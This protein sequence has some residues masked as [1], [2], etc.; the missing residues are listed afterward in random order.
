MICWREPQAPDQT[1]TKETRKHASKHATRTRHRRAW[2]SS[3]SHTLRAGYAEPLR[4]S[5]LPFELRHTLSDYDHK[6]G[7][8]V[9]DQHKTG[10]NCKTGGEKRK[11]EHLYKV[12]HVSRERILPQVCGKCVST[13]LAQQETAFFL[14]F[15]LS[16]LKI[17]HLRFAVEHLSP[18]LAK[19]SQLDLY[20]LEFMSHWKGDH[21]PQSQV[22][23]L[24]G[25]HL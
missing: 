5:F 22:N 10:L 8:C 16:S 23:L 2:D 7:V 3:V 18:T 1:S 19:D 24:Q 4:K 14:F 9:M 25:F 11:R 12:W 13:S 6:L 15:A 17:P 20:F 21:Q